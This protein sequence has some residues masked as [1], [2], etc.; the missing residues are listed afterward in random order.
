[1]SKT[2][3]AVRHFGLGG[4][5]SLETAVMLPPLPTVIV[6]EHW[7]HWVVEI[8]P[9]NRSEKLL[10]CRFFSRNQLVDAGPTVNESGWGSTSTVLILMPYWSEAMI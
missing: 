9:K 3:T 10:S 5:E 8:Q 7:E 6:W 1:M 4:R 2:I